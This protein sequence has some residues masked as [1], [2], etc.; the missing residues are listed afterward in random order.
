MFAPVAVVP[1]PVRLA[2]DVSGIRHEVR[3]RVLRRIRAC[4]LEPRRPRHRIVRR[5]AGDLRLERSKPRRLRRHP[6]L[7]AVQV[8]ETVA[9]IRLIELQQRRFEEAN[10]LTR[11]LLAMGAATRLRGVPQGP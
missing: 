9:P 1:L 7:D 2:S 10:K 5:L 3:M 6:T 8:R 4:G 11:I